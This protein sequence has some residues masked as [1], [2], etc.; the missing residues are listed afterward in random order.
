L[1]EVAKEIEIGKLAL[2]RIVPPEQ[3]ENLI[4][5][6]TMMRRYGIKKATL[7]DD[8]RKAI[9]VDEFF[10]IRYV[11]SKKE[12]SI[13]RKAIKVTEKK[14]QGI[15][16]KVIGD[17]TRGE[18]KGGKAD[19]KTIMD[20]AKK[21]KKSLWY[22]LKQLASGIKVELE[23]TNK[24]KIAAEIARDQLLEDADYYKKLKKIEKD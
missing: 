15:K 4:G 14:I 11:V 16:D 18:L 23:H 7:T 10:G 20:I 8:L 24:I 13:I 6:I 9:M 21:H 19:R 12:D 22:M 3:L 1:K 5:A 17:K 2:R